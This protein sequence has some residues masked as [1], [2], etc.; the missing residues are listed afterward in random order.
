VNRNWSLSKYE[1]RFNMDRPE[2]TDD[3]VNRTADAMASTVRNVGEAAT[4]AAERVGE[5]LDQGKAALID[6]QEALA[7][8]T[9]ECIRTTEM[10]V[11]DN[12]W[13][14]VGMAAGLGL[15]VGLLVG[16]R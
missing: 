15:I 13:Q 1:R 2:N 12:P 3:A 11:R 14:A 4:S 7:E 16:R 9:R 6:L 8:K 10:Y 5:S